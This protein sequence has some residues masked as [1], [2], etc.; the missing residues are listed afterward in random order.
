MEK[1]YTEKELFDLLQSVED[2][3]LGASVIDLGL[4]YRAEQR[5]G[6]IE[7]DYTLT[8]PGCPL[9]EELRTDIVLTL[10][11]KTGVNLIR[12]NLVWSP[13]WDASLMTDELKLEHGI[14]IW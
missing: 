2:P 10:K 11:A 6:T 8:S 12:A 13:P 4:I 3:E 5:D 14:P 1:R 7:V 9:G